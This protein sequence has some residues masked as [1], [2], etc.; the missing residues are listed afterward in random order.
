M[1][2]S[3]N[4][5]PDEISKSTLKREMTALQKIGETLVDMPQ[6]Q[7]DKIPLPDA[8]LEAIMLARNIKSQGA[9]RR[10]LQYIGKLMRTIELEPIQTAI[11]NAKLASTQITAQFHQAEE[12]RE[13]LINEGDD[14][15]QAFVTLHTEADR[16]K[17][18]QLT[19]QAQHDRK[20]EKNTGAEKT[21]FRYLREII[22]KV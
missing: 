8:L 14:A 13:R 21:L 17:L 11:K 5:L 4:K 3:D 9:K 15:V 22:D 20:S 18:R 19:R 16:Q 10:Q 2:L 6:S 12:W 7:L 1:P